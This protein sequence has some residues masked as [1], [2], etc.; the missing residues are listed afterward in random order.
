MRTEA[1][2]YVVCEEWWTGPHRSREVAERQLERIEASGQ[3]RAA[4]HI[5]A[6]YSHHTEPE[7]AS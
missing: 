2:W 4:H 7:P 3:C 5:Q 6:G 1:E